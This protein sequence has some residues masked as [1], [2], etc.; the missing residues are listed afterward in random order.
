[1]L[2]TDIKTHIEDVRAINST[3][4]DEYCHQLELAYGNNMMSE[5]GG[6]AIENMFENIDIEHKKALDFGSG[7]GGVAFYLAEK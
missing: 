6:D 3:Y 7:L 5:G 2:K 4:T 1:M